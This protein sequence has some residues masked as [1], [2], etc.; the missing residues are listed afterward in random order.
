MGYFS[1]SEREFGRGSKGRYDPQIPRF[2][3]KIKRFLSD[4]AKFKLDFLHFSVD[5][6]TAGL[7]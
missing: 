6:S 4:F 1:T 3:R 7:C 2:Y 5:F